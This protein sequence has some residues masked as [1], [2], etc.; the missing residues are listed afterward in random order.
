MPNY[1][2]SLEAAHDLLQRG[3]M[4]LPVPY[5]E[6]NPGAE[7]WQGWQAFTTTEA[8]LPQHFNGEPKNI[9][10]LLGDKSGVMKARSS[11]ARSLAVNSC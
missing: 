11:I 9:G 4:P 7:G 8:E 10:V 3:W 1:P 2:T 6:K 5:R